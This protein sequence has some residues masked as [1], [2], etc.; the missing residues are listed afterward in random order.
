MS[1]GR[2]LVSL[3]DVIYN[4]SIIQIKSLIKEGIDI[5]ENDIKGDK[6]IG[7]IHSVIKWVLTLTF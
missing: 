4:E 2:F 3:K 1:V 5:F 7:H 6:D